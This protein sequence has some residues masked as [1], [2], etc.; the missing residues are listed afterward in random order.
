MNPVVHFEMP[1]DDRQRMAK[2]YEPAFGWTTQAMG[3]EMGDYVVALATAPLSAQT[4]RIYSSRVRQYLAWLAAAE[5]DGDP[6]GTTDGR[7]SHGCDEPCP[8]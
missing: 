4:R 2:F 8:D 5:V 1:F 6:L 7:G 3:P